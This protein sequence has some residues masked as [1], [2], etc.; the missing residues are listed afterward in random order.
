MRMLLTEWQRDWAAQQPQVLKPI[1]LDARVGGQLFVVF[2]LV[3]HGELQEAC[4]EAESDEA[5]RLIHGVLE[6]AGSAKEAPVDAEA[7]ACK[8]FREG[9]ALLRYDPTSAIFVNRQPRPDLFRDG[10]SLG[11]YVAEFASVTPADVL[12]TRGALQRAAA[13][14]RQQ[15][16][17][18]DKLHKHDLAL[19]EVLADVGN[20]KLTARVEQVF[21]VG[22]GLTEAHAGTRVVF[23][24][25][26]GVWG[27]IAQLR[28]GE[29]A[30][31][32][33]QKITDVLYENSYAGHL[34]IRDVDGEP[35]AIVGLPLDLLP[36]ALR[37]HAR[38][39]PEEPHYSAVRYGAME[40]YLRVVA[41][42]VRLG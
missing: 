22:N 6:S 19:L 4:F 24:G 27:D 14:E 28:P 40:S 36:P 15:V 35:H 17:L 42:Q 34:P 41:R 33:L 20:G 30:L 16:F 21:A 9:Y 31:V 25:S 2:G 23:V 37:A 13:A 12:A 29:R 26:G 11:D 8:L 3:A 1:V 18:A 5:I 38:V 39:A 7:R 32:F 10:A